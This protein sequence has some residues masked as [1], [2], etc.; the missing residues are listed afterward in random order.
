MKIHPITNMHW[1]INQDVYYIL[2]FQNWVGFGAYP[3]DRFKD[4]VFGNIAFFCVAIT[5]V[6]PVWF[7]NYMPD[8]Q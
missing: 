7:Y 4:T 2:L 1:W 5:F 6:L 8:Y 3:W